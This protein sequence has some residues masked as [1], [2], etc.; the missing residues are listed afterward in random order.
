MRK[1]TCIVC[2]RGCELTVDI[3]N[4]YKV[5]GHA[6]PRGAVYGRKECLAPSRTLT[7]TVR[8]A[9]GQLSRVPVKSGSELPKDLLTAAMT[10]LESVCLAAPVHRGQVAAANIL[11]SG[12]DIIVTRDVDS[13]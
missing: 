2:P 12:I 9:S 5:S 1:M 3:E 10:E 11:N 4:D 8:L 6:C 7:T 13:L